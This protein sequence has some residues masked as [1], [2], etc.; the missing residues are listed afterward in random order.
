[1]KWISVEEKMPEL[2]YGATVIGYDSFYGRIAAAY[3]RNERLVFLDSDDCN[4][5]H[6]VNLPAPGSKTG[7]LNMG[8]NK[9]V[10]ENDAVP[11]SY[12]WLYEESKTD[13]LFSG[14]IISEIGD[15]E[16]EHG[17]NE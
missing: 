3:V 8:V 15:R 6:W 10:D 13:N 17:E 14:E 7:R 16:V 5:T 9:T 11:F 12:T 1:M 4:I 2:E